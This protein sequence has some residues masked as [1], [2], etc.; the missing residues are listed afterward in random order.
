MVDIRTT[1]TLAERAIVWERETMLAPDLTDGVVRLDGFTFDDV[2]AHL[3]GEDE[4]IAR[5]F[6]WWPRRSTLETVRA[7]ICRWTDGWATGGA[8]RAFAVRE[9]ATGRLV[10]HCELR[11][12]DDDIAHASY[13][14]AAHA[15]RLGY[16]ARALRLASDWGFREL[17]IIRLELYIEPDNAAS[18]AVARRAGF[19]EEGLLR[20]R[21]RIGE[22]RR[23]AILYAKLASDR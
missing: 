13:S 10:G 22:A 1:Q 4:E 12:Q 7:A 16:A 6:A 19:V 5:R 15:R 3:A 11:V 17:A 18:R 9:V 8:T 14:T 20:C 2:A 21:L 23:D